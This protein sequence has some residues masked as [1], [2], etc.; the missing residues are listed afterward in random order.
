MFSQFGSRSL[1]RFSKLNSRTDSSEKETASDAS[2]G[3]PPVDFNLY[4]NYWH[5]VLPSVYSIGKLMHP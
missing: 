4:P 3:Y 5:S 1:R 2:R